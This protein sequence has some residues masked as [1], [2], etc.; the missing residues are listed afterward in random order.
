MC[1]LSD[2]KSFRFA[3]Q[4]LRIFSRPRVACRCI[5]DAHCTVHIALYT[6]ICNGAHRQCWLSRK[7]TMRRV[8]TVGCALERENV[9]QSSTSR[10]Y[11]YEQTGRDRQIDFAIIIRFSRRMHI[12][13]ESEDKRAAVYLYTRLFAN[14]IKELQQE[15]KSFLRAVW[16]R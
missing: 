9:W 6:C 2:K 1:I 16:W 12:A 15:G 3:A 4:I 8:T 10:E 14:V 11:W 7:H 13:E 5:R